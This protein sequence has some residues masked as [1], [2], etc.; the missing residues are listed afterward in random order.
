VAGQNHHGDVTVVLKP[1]ARGSENEID[2]G[3]VKESLPENML[4]AVQ[5]GLNEALT[6]GVLLGYPVVDVAAEVKAVTLKDSTSE[7]GLRVAAAMACKQ[8]L[9]AASPFLLDPIMK[10]EVFVPEEFT[11]EVIGDI[12]QRSGKIEAIEHRHDMQVIKTVVPLAQMF[13]YSTSLRSATQG[14]GVF[15][16]HFSHFD[17]A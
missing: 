3:A 7:L 14:R 16:M 6:S 8:A 12:N 1:L 17:K 10:V 2:T 9:D 13:G 15:S 5:S 11:G 4:A